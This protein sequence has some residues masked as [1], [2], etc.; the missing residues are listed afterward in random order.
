MESTSKPTADIAMEIPAMPKKIS[1]KK[2]KLSWRKK[3]AKGYPGPI[4]SENLVF[5]VETKGNQ[6]T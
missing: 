1:K 5:T 6:L 2:L 4:V 3:I